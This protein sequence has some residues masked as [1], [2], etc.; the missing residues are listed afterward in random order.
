MTWARHIDPGLCGIYRVVGDEVQIVWEGGRRTTAI[1]KS[2]G[3]EI[4]G[5]PYF[6]QTKARANFTLNGV[7]VTWQYY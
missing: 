4:D 1:R 2:N 3:L 7:Y 6:L 5:R